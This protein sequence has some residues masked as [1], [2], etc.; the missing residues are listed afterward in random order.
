MNT[1]STG[2]SGAKGAG[3]SSTSSKPVSAAAGIASLV[4]SKGAPVATAR[5]SL[6]A[7]EYPPTAELQ[8]SW[9]NAVSRLGRLLGVGLD[10]DHDVKIHF[11]KTN[12]EV[13][14]SSWGYDTGKDRVVYDTLPRQAPR[15]LLSPLHHRTS[16]DSPHRQVSALIESS[17][18]EQGDFQ[19]SIV[20]TFRMWIA[21]RLFVCAQHA[22]LEPYRM[23]I[24]G[25]IRNRR[26]EVRLMWTSTGWRSS[27]GDTPAWTL[28]TFLITGSPRTRGEST[29]R[30]N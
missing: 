21:P 13:H 24:F 26:A 15:S 16:W 19:H 11:N 2:A 14:L 30:S 20:S 12:G 7:G 5:P 9:P 29:A 17:C 3:S 22:R 28:Q 18:M 10:Q 4:P 8:V 6:K 27:R 25:K 23:F 1:T